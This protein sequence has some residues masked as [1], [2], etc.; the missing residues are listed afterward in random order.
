MDAP[1]VLVAPDSFKGTFSADEVARAIGV[2][3]R[4]A[5]CAVDLAP[6]ADGG[7]GTAAVLARAAGARAVRLSV[8]GPLGAPVDAEFYLGDDGTA[9]IDAAAASGL[10]L[11]PEADRTPAAAVDASTA[12]TGAL[13]AAASAAGAREIRLGV[14]GSATTDGGRGAIE[15]IGPGGL[16]GARL[17]VLCDVTSTYLEAPVVFGPQKGADPATVDRLV[18]RLDD[19][20][21]TLPRDPR[22]VPMSGAAGGLA[23]GLWAAFGAELL[24]GAAHVLEAVALRKRAERATAVVTGEGRF[25]AQSALGKLTGAVRDVAGRPTHLIVG[26]TDLDAA[27]VTDAGFASLRVAGNPE[28]LAAAGRSLGLAM[29]QGP[30]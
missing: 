29:V 8:P 7:E 18:R 27:A 22:G 26:S 21:G 15:A 11:V 24:P 6:V 1:L 25:D 3:L 2:G 16:R 13:V 20:A 17:R 12:G 30:R 9:F 14:G 4:L 19:Y 23:G 10:A 28:S 5:G